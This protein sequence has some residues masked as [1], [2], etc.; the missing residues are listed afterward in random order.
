LPV[1]GRA[2]QLSY[3]HAAAGAAAAFA[4]SNG[5]TDNLLLLDVLQA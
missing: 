5:T 4:E 2:Q 1:S 3:V